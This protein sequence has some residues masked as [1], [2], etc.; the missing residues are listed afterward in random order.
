MAY[1]VALKPAAV[2]QLAQLPQSAQRRV[3]RK[4]DSL[5][6]NPRPRGAKK[7]EGIK[8][9]YRVRAGDYRII[10]RILRK[11][12]LVVVVRVRHRKDAYRKL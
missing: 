9:L 8:D 3:A 10:Y 7:L 6:G 2:E 4:I 11:V 12:L 5:A 1:R